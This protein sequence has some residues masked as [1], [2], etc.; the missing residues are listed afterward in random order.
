MLIPISLNFDQTDIRMIMRDSDPWWVL[1]DV[2]AILEIANPRNVA[3]RLRDWQKGVHSMDTLGGPQESVIVNEAGIYKLVL[4]SRKPVAEEFERWL[5][6]DVLPAIRKYGCYPTPTTCKEIVLD[7]ESPWEPHDSRTI[8]ERF[9]LERKRWEAETGYDFA[10][11]VP[12]MSKSIVRAIEGN[13]GG[14]RKGQRIEYLLYAGIDVLYVLTGTK[15]LTASERQLRD[16][17]RGAARM[18]RAQLLAAM[19]DALPEDDCALL[20]Y[21]NDTF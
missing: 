18:D 14:I 19:K 6:C 7:D 13:L 10:T 11:T 1:N 9:Q 15:T 20:G 12:T 16:A 5:T 17:Y 3:A 2:C 8:G 4:S 21:E